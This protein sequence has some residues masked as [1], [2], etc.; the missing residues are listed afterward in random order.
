M[1]KEILGHADITTTMMYA[2][3]SPS[4]LVE[5]INRLYFS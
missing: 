5:E 1:K 4:Y 2:H 3:L